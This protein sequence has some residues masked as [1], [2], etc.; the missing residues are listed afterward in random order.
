MK[1]L[2]Y[3]I[4]KVEDVRYILSPVLT[5][6]EDAGGV[7]NGM[8]EL[9]MGV[10][11]PRRILIIQVRQRPLLE[12]FLAGAFRMQPGRALL[13][14]PAGGLGN[15]PKDGE[16]A[17]VV[18]VGRRLMPDRLAQVEEV[19]LGDCDLLQFDIVLARVVRQWDQ[20]RLSE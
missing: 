2:P 15:G 1:A 19:L 18:H 8:V 4:G 3:E 11:Q 12:L 14:Q 10:L 6:W 5:K 9:F 17:F 7:E 13:H 16:L 20:S